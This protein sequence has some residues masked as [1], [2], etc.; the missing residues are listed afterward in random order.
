MSTTSYPK[1]VKLSPPI[2]CD[3]EEVNGRKAPM[4]GVDVPIR[5]AVSLL[6]KGWR[7]CRVSDAPLV[8]EWAEKEKQRLERAAKAT[9]EIEKKRL[10]AEEEKRREEIKKG[11][12][13]EK[14]RQEEAR[15]AHAAKKTKPAINEGKE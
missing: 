1:S 8:E 7:T 5:D 9:E 4:S 15:K 2:G 12:E 13:E 14:K 11:L 3:S 6:A 10:A